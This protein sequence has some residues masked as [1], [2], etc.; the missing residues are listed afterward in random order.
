MVGGR[1]RADSQGM[2]RNDHAE[3]CTPAQERLVRDHV[4]LVH[5]VVNDVRARIPKHVPAA[6]LESAAMF[7][8]Y[9]AARTF[10]PERGVPFD[11]W[12]RQRMRGALLDELRSRDWAGRSVRADVKRVQQIEDD[13]ATE[14]GR[15][16]TREEISARAAI[17]RDRLHRVRDDEHCSVLLNYD[18]VFAEATEHDALADHA[19]DPSEHLLSRETRGYLIDAVVALPERLR[20][21]IVGYYF[22]ERPMLELA[23]ELGV[24]DSRISQMRAEAVSLLRDGVL[25]QLEPGAVSQETLPDGRAARRKA[26]YYAEVAQSSDLKT[27]LSADAPS[28]HER[29]AAASEA[30]TA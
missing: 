3:Q 8:L 30:V 4:P 24:T 11:A 21:V 27:R 22:E 23:E 7:A 12:A 13:L 15:T 18:S 29:I 1:T 14:L 17:D 20:R 16:P 2:E 25:S 5:H 28:V 9:Q 10:D 26:A 19:A 6:D